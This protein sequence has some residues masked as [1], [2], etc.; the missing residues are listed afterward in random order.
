M[1]NDHTDR[2]LSR[3]RLLTSLATIGGSL[4][5]AG[6]GTWALLDDRERGAMTVQAGT[7]SLATGDGAV[8]PTI[9][10]DDVEAGASGAKR[11]EL[12]NTGSLAAGLTVCVDSVTAGGSGPA[13]DESP[14]VDVVFNGCGQARLLFDRQP[15]SPVSVTVEHG[16]GDAR[17]VEIGT[18]D[19][20]RDGDGWRFTYTRTGGKGGYIQ[21]VLAA[22]RRWDNDD[23]SK[24]G[25]SAP[26]PSDGAEPTDLA[27]HVSVSLGIDPASGAEETLFDDVPVEAL[28]DG[29]TCHGA[30]G[31]LGSGESAA[32]VVD[33]D[34]DASP[35]RLDG[36][37]TIDLTVTLQT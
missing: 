11:L 33:W 9:T 28:A 19:L 8:S 27:E 26:N 16:D 18:D 36:R 1:G 20:E 14:I 10:V 24:A 37:I 5:A 31:T 2:P 29:A 13:P 23:C 22:D 25:K 15:D 30:S 7:V 6:V 17:S 21:R 12:T 34:A 32:L 3:R 35:A 4:S